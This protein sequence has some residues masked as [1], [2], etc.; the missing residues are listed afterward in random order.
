M[1]SF[2][3]EKDLYEQDPRRDPEGSTE[4]VAGA[5]L[6]FT[7]GGDVGPGH[8]KARRSWAEGGGGKGWN[9]SA[10]GAGLRMMGRSASDCK[11][12]W[13]AQGRVQRASGAGPGSWCYPVLL[14]L[15]LGWQSYLPKPL[16]LE[17]TKWKGEEE[18]TPRI[19][20]GDW[21]PCRAPLRAWA[22]WGHCGGGDAQPNTPSHA[23]DFH[24]PGPS[25]SQAEGA[26]YINWR[27]SP[28]GWKT[29]SSALG[30]NLSC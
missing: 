25:R 5:W 11:G 6:G 17:N 20:A 15:E 14:P 2:R 24:F 19:F 8:G 10:P 16:T 13:G 9:S 23:A 28:V 30:L 1:E 22:R 26:H 21:H 4:E 29:L 3:P 27:A 7:E 18:P 12:K